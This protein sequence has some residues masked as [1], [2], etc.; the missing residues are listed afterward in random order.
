M[1]SSSLLVLNYSLFKVTATTTTMTAV[2]YFL[3]K[4]TAIIFTALGRKET[5]DCCCNFSRFSNNDADR[6]E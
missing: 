5:C 3:C 2:V 4:K 6:K 1:F